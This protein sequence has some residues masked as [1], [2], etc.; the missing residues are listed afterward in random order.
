MCCLQLSRFILNFVVPARAQYDL[1]TGHLK[2]PVLIEVEETTSVARQEQLLKAQAILDNPM[3]PETKKAQVRQMLTQTQQLRGYRLCAPASEKP[4]FRGEPRPVVQVTDM[5]SNAQ[6]KQRRRPS[7]ISEDVVSPVSE[8]G[9]SSLKGICITCNKPVFCTQKRVRTQLG[10]LHIECK[11]SQGSSQAS[12]DVQQLNV[13]TRMD[14]M[15]DDA[16]KA[17]VK[18]AEEADAVVNAAAATVAAVKA[19][20]TVAAVKAE[21]EVTTRD[22]AAKQRQQPAVT[23]AA[24]SGWFRGEVQQQRSRSPSPLSRVQS[25]LS[26]GGASTLKGICVTCNEPVFASQL[27][28]KSALGYYHE[29]CVTETAQGSTAGD[30]IP[31]STLGS[32]ADLT[33]ELCKRVKGICVT[34]NEPVYASQLRVKSALGFH[35]EECANENATGNVTGTPDSNPGTAEP[36][37]PVQFSEIA[38]SAQGRRSP[39]PSQIDRVQSNLSEGGASTL[40]GICV[41][42]NQPV[43]ASQLR[44]KSALGYYHEECATD[45]PVFASQLCVKSATALLSPKQVN[46]SKSP[47]TP[48]PGT[49]TTAA[50][51]QGQLLEGLI[52]ADNSTMQQPTLEVTVDVPRW[53]TDA[54]LDTQIDD[55]DLPKWSSNLPLDEQQLLS[56]PNESEF[57]HISLAS[58]SCIPE[59][60]TSSVSPASPASRANSWTSKRSDDADESQHESDDSSVDDLDDLLTPTPTKHK[61][62]TNLDDDLDALLAP[63]PASSPKHKRQGNESSNRDQTPLSPSRKIVTSTVHEIIQ[64]QY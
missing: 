55:D 13:L 38:F 6:G 46:R 35:H 12:A 33:L 18:A 63:S 7:P 58:P 16:V 36:G 24:E 14:T 19:A 52:L 23:Q 62:K 29:E 25:N 28:V 61:R 57:P 60:P 51:R 40:K 56:S 53:V 3:L 45:Q 42:C 54:S 49:P 5:T 20:T 44:V 30:S 21:E 4:W 26:E 47:G 9:V 48:T 32:P 10:Y 31:A 50:R 2:P 17:A 41:T 37:S 43:F 15:D 59:E 34:C 1:N 64:S 22:L 11:V 39:S 8:G 27:R